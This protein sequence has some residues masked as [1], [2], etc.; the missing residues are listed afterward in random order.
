MAGPRYFI[1]YTPVSLAFWVGLFLI[2]FIIH[3][4]VYVLVALYV[5]FLIRSFSLTLWWTGAFGL[6]YLAIRYLK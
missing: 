5:Y 3:K 2:A 4:I 6:F 1:E